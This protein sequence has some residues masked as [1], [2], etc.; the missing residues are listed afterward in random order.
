VS[1]DLKDFL[2]RVLQDL[3]TTRHVFLDL[4]HEEVLAVGGK[5]KLGELHMLLVLEFV[6]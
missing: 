2:E 5:S 1:L 3:D 4:A 6:L